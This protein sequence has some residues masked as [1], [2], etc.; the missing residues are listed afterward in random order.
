MKTYKVYVTRTTKISNVF[1]VEAEDAIQAQSTAINLTNQKYNNYPG[2]IVENEITAVLSPNTEEDKYWEVIELLKWK[3]DHDYE[4]ITKELS[5]YNDDF[6]K[7]LQDFCYSK[8]EELRDNFEK[9][10]L[11]FGSDGINVSE[12]GWYDLRADVVGRGKDFYYS[13]TK[14]KLQQMADENDYEENFLYSFNY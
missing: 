13:I 3:N 11:K 7:K 4:R 6:K 9:E 14:E 5:V 12:D 10:W 2:E 8:I 1:E